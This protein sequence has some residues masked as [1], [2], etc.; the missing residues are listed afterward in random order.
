MSGILGVWNSQKPTP[1][2][3]MLDDLAVLGKEGSGEWCD[4]AVGL[5]LGRTQFF[6]TPESCLEEAIVIA[7]GCVLVWD[8]RIDDR[9][10]LISAS[11]AASMPVTDA[12]L[13][14][15]GY[16]RW[17][18]ECIRHLIGEF[19]FILWDTVQQTLF[20]GCDCVGGRTLAYYWDGQTLLLS[21]RVLTLLLH[22]QVEFKLNDL[23]VAHTLCDLGS[24]P[25]GITAF[26]SIHRLLPGEALILHSGQL[27]R[28]KIGR[29][30]VEENHAT[31]RPERYHEKFWDLLNHAVGDRLRSCRPACVTLSGGLDSSTVTVAL[32]N[33]LSSLDAFSITTDRYPEFDERQPIQAFLQ[34]YPQ[35][36]WHSVN[37]NEAWSLSEPWEQLPCSD[38]PLIGFTMPMH[39]QMMAQIQQA[40]FGLVFDGE[41]GDE[42][43]HASLY[44]LYEQGNWHAMGQQLQ[45]DPRWSLSLLWELILPSLPQ[46]I[47]SLWLKRSL[48]RSGTIPPWISAEYLQQPTTQTAIQQNLEMMLISRQRD[49]L[50]CCLESTGVVAIGQAYKPIKAHF[51]QNFAS[52][53]QDQRL[54]EFALALPPVL[55][56]HPTQNKIFLREV[57]RTTLPDEVRS[58]PKTNYFDPL[59]YAGLGQSQ[60]A[61]DRLE[62][63][64]QC[65]DLQAVINFDRVQNCLRWYQEMYAKSYTPG[66][67][68]HNTLANQLYGVL[69]FCDWYQ[70][71]QQSYGAL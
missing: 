68:F 53:L 66:Q 26:Q 3:Q 34:Q 16:R 21:S 19:V 20:V 5:S 63:V 52:P 45:A 17:G 22:P 69:T 59:K 58:R 12:Q 24:H 50:T 35:V 28:R 32:L 67:P 38:D 1:W 36:N 71:V 55:Q 23:Y 46:S 10:A 62:K 56:S 57:N 9:A 60:Q 41:W 70:R 7:Q 15:E 14:I 4:P 31:E 51:Q 8:G 48:R 2:Q 33:H 44:D 13:M 47:S 39:L 29:L 61:L 37:C 25:P 49:V 27:Q 43:F 42:L 6:N 40:G 54:I 11:I 30:K 18:T 65:T 64:R